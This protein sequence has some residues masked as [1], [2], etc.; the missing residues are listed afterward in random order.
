MG[1]TTYFAGRFNLNKQLDDETFN[2]IDGLAK[3]RRMKRDINKLE[4][5]GFSKVETFGEE[6]EYF[7]KN[8]DEFGQSYDESIIDYN[9]PPKTQPGL[10]L[11]WIPTEDKM[12]LEWDGNEKFYDS[13]EWIEYLINKILEPRGYI[14]NGIVNAQGEDMKDKY[15]INIINNKVYNKSGLSKEIPIPLRLY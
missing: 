8:D 11:Q 7:I 14:L 9:S 10:W 13:V 4:E 5:M 3:T 12:G 1:Y 2:L 6:G 15:H